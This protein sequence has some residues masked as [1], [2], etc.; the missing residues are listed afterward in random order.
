MSVPLRVLLIEDSDDDAELVVR[1]LR[2]GGYDLAYAR[3]ETAEAMRDALAHHAWDLVVSDYSMPQF[4]GPAALQLLQAV[5]MDLPFIIVSGTIGEETAV[6]AM[7]AGAHDFLMKGNLTRLIPAVERELREA[8][9]RRERRRAEARFAGVLHAT[10]EAIIAVDQ[11]QRIVLFNASAERIFGYT[12]TE[13][14]GHPLD[15]LLSPSLIAAHQQY[16]R[17]FAAPDSSRRMSERLGEFVGRRK[18][19]SEFPLEASIATLS[20]EGE[21]IFTVFLQ[22]ISVRKQ[23]EAQLFQSQKME[24]IGQ[25]AGG[26]AHDFNNLLTAITGYMELALDDLPPDQPVYNDVAE[27]QKAAMRAATL[28]RQLLA[29]ARKQIIDLQV[30]NLNSLVLE[31]DKL[32]RRV[33]GEHIE[34]ITH[35]APD[36]KPV[37]VDSGQIEQV[38]VNLAV[39]AHDAM[40]TGGK[41]TIETTNAVFGSDDAYQHAVVT[42]GE[43]VILTISDTGSGMDSVVQ[44][45]LFEPFFT[46]KEPGKGTGLGLATCYGIIKQHSGHIEVYSEVG[47]GTTFKIYLPSVAYVEVSSDAVR[48]LGEAKT[49]PKGTATLLVV[50]DEPLIRQL[51]CRV[52]RQQ[53]YTVLDATNGE[54]ALHAVHAYAGVPIDLLVTDVVMPRIGGKVLADQ[55]IAMYPHIKV[56]FVSGYATDAIVRY[57]R[58]TPGTNFLAKPFTPTALARKVQEVLD[59]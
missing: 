57:G 20:Q 26:I 55:L 31:L 49:V 44:Q 45:H 53:G 32:L 16:I 28:T 48:A 35:P 3:V 29:F 5:G 13:A 1:T 23:L 19:G 11:E 43:Y 6:T 42:P 56:L 10:V 52:L 24:A 25:L 15:I 30:L 38:I 54:E 18:D 59:T 14:H 22:D 50:E 47:H 58:L 33:L 39:N 27:A 9:E 7:K 36:L 17:T 12:A 46:T 8:A 4:S 41:L 40:P 2:R 51:S 37:K 34:L 21:T